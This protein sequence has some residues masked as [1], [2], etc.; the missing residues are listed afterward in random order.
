M[1][2]N[3]V[4]ARAH[5]WAGDN[6]TAQIILLD[7]STVPMAEHFVDWSRQ[8]AIQGIEL[9]R[10]GALGPRQAAQAEAAGMRCIQELILLEARPPLAAQLGTGRSRVHT[11]RCR[12]GRF[13]PGEFDL[14]ADVDRAAFGEMWR[15]DAST[16]AD[17]CTVTPS[18]H[19]RVVRHPSSAD[20]GWFHRRP[21][22]GFLLSGRAGRVGYIQ[23]LA[24]EPAFHRRGIAAA[25]LGEALTWM[26]SA[27][28]DQV[29]VNTHLDNVAALALYHRHGF[30]D[31]ADRLRVFEGQTPL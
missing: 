10:T 1:Q 13:G 4:P 17:I 3:Q 6:R 31:L 26:R 2:Q 8:L 16:L 9:M 12:V 15:L 18:Y 29:F 5:P 14:L 23:R 7:P 27:G 11:G 28:T 19:A 25:L 24:V 30:R 22:I 21:P 20:S